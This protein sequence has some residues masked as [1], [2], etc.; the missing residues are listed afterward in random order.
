MNANKNKS[1]NKNMQKL[2][3]SLFVFN[4]NSTHRFLIKHLI[5]FGVHRAKSV[6]RTMKLFGSNHQTIYQNPDL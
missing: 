2:I 1:K 4:K 5:Q 6:S 3:L